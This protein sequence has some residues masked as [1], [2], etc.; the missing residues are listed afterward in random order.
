M[1]QAKEALGR[2]LAAAEAEEAV[3]VEL[4]TQLELAKLEV[5]NVPR[6]PFRQYTVECVIGTLH[7]SSCV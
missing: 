7:V 2:A 3:A 5:I 4:E 6:T 1:C